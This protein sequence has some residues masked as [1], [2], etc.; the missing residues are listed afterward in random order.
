MG[1]TWEP[2]L[3][4]YMVQQTDQ[5]L[6]LGTSPV[7]THLSN[8]KVCEI[9]HAFFDQMKAEA[10][11]NAILAAVQNKILK[12]P[13]EQRPKDDITCVV[14]F[15][16]KK[17]LIKNASGATAQSKLDNFLSA[18]DVIDELEE[19]NMVTGQTVGASQNDIKR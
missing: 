12:I 11:A 10:A 8:E 3:S 1:L 13:P 17:L 2:D 19:E 7:W 18:E 5:V 6:I 16:D 4:E 15:L 14:I 9:V